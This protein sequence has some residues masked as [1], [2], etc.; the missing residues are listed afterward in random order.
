MQAWTWET[1]WSCYG[2][3]ASTAQTGR[4]AARI[5]IENT[6]EGDGA[7]S[8]IS[9]ESDADW[10]LHSV[11]IKISVIIRHLKEN[12]MRLSFKSI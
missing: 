11:L 2:F 8:S 7:A 10:H 6:L 4:P 3:L 12:Q 9:C 5:P 1:G